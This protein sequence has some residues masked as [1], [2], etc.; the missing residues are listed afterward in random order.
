MRQWGTKNFFGKGGPKKNG[1]PQIIISS[2]PSKTNFMFWDIDLGSMN[3]FPLL[4]LKLKF[5][6]FVKWPV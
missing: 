3:S 4:K 2:K 5:L 6:L 1:F